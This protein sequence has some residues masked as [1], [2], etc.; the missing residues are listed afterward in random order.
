MHDLFHV[1][2]NNSLNQNYSTLTVQQAR[3]VTKNY[4]QSC[5]QSFMGLIKQCA[6]SYK[7]VGDLYMS[8]FRNG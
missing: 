1:F 8:L 2:G 6:R 3:S 4:N 7:F 5:L